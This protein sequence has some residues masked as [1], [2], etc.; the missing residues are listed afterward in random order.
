MAGTVA[1][2]E[3]RSRR[4]QPVVGFEQGYQTRDPVDRFDFLHGQL[5][6]ESFLDG[7]YDLKVIQGIPL[8]NL[9][10]HQIAA[11]PGRV[12][13]EHVAE[14]LGQTLVHGSSTAMWRQSSKEQSSRVT[15]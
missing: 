4:L 12:E 6:V 8:I 5:Q 9:F 15:R 14:N 10:A 2:P 7:G 1:G 13:I 3:R 11:D